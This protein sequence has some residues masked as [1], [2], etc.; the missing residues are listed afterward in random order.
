MASIAGKVAGG[1]ASAVGGKLIDKALNKDRSKR[2]ERAERAIL[3]FRPRGFSSGDVTARFNPATG[4]FEI[5]GSD[6]LRTLPQ[7]LSGGFADRAAR[8]EGLLS[9]LPTAPRSTEA[10]INA[11]RS[12]SRASVGNLR[13]NLARRRLGGS[14]FA[15]D[16]ISR[17][18]AEF[19]EREGVLRD[20]L[21]QRDFQNELTLAQ[22]RIGLVDEITR[23]NVAKVQSLIQ[24]MGL[25][26]NLAQ[27]ILASIMGTSSSNA[28]IQAE[29]LGRTGA[30][31]DRFFG[32]AIDEIGATTSSAVTRSIPKIGRLFN[33]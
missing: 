22:Q 15:A 19:A 5:A 33:G 4:L 25:D 10:A 13:D 8:L 17:A 28:A 27:P 6:R 20:E 26:A 32:P 16:A 24:G 18:E 23:A 29:L 14:S 3:D 9:T 21:S 7:N 12:R 2:A 1:L 31:V 30:G 11:L